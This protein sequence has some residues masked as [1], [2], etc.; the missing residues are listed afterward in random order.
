MKNKQENFLKIIICLALPIIIENIFQTLLGTTDTY[1]AGKLHDNAIAAIGVTNLIMNIFIAFYTAISVGASAVISRFIGRGDK[2]KANEAIQHSLLLGI[3]IGLVIGIIS[4]VFYKPI[5]QISGANDE[6]MVY[7]IPYYLIVAV[8]SIF[9]CLS[10]IL[11]SFLRASKDTK[12]PMYATGIAN[13]LNIVLNITFMNLGMGIMGLALATTISR[14]VVTILLLLKI[15]NTNSEIKINLRGI[16]YNKEMLKSITSI[17]IPAGLEKLIMRTGQLVYN[18][19][20][21]SLGTASY[22]AHS[23]GGSIEGYSYIPAFGFGMA[24]ATLVGISLGENDGVKA[25]K[26]TFL[27]NGITTIIMI[28]I[29]ICFFLFAPQLASIFTDTKEVQEKVVLVLRLISFFQPF[30]A[31]TQ[32]M[33]SALQGAG[34]TKFPM[35][36]TI[37][38]IW[39]VRVGIGYILAVVFKLGLFGVW[40]GYAM[41]L[42][43]RGILLLVR[44]LRGKW[45]KIVI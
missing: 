28:L 33:T 40:C 37:I 22:V 39:V 42:T 31:L 35:Y 14:I 38:G 7:A 4:L 16:R 5:L 45:Q 23:I 25:K 10:H 26:I 9:L 24:T 12:T 2:E 20:I 41:D 6:V 34:D 32:I 29:G 13:L 1:F 8:P 43:I 19:M 36:A 18:G 15:K 11:S 17:S 44:F 30:A 3:I 27:S 21:I